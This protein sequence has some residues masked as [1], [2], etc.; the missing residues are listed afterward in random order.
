MRHHL[1]L[2]RATLV[3]GKTENNKCWEGCE[4]AA[5]LVH[6]CGIVKWCSPA[7]GHGMLVSPKLNVKLPRY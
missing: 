7:T 4:K 5:T 6:C 1:T 2:I 3:Q